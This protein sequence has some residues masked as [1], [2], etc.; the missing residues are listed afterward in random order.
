[1]HKKISFG[2]FSNRTNLRHNPFFHL[3][4]PEAYYSF[5]L[6]MIFTVIV[7]YFLTSNESNL[8][9][10]SDTTKNIVLNSSF[11]LIGVLGFLI[12]GLAILTGTV[13]TKVVD[14]LHHNNKYENLMSIF[15]SFYHLGTVV[16]GYI[17]LFILI[18][19]VLSINFHP[20]YLIWIYIILGFVLSYGLFFI[21]FYSVH[22]LKSSIAIFEISYKYSI[23]SR[24]QNIFESGEFF[25]LRLDAILLSMLKKDILNKTEFKSYLEEC[26]ETQYDFLSEDKKEELKKKCRKYYNF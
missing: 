8:S 16:G 7:Y 26:I 20:V 24:D 21:I 1:M 14:K 5:L 3:Y 11:A 2:E 13:N 6:S 4:K 15:F 23:E 22:L 19:F 25:D 17:I 10:V 18:Y 9:Y 12:S